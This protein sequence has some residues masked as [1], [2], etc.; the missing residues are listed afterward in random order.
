MPPRTTTTRVFGGTRPAA[1]AAAVDE[2]LSP[3]RYVLH[4]LALLVTLAVSVAG[5]AGFVVLMG[6]R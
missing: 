6:E 5:I 4:A 2:R 3:A 1:A